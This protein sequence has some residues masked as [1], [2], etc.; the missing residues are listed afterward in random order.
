M[1]IIHKALTMFLTKHEQ[2]FTQN[3]SIQ[4]PKK[5]LEN[6]KPIEETQNYFSIQ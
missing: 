4:F 2:I 3:F 6:Y 1:T 5:I